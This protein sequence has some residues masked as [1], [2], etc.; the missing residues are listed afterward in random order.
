[1][2]E[3]VE[4]AL[5]VR[6]K[7]ARRI[8]KANK[9]TKVP[10]SLLDDP[11][12]KAAIDNLPKNYNFEIPKI[13]WRIKE[14]NSKTVALQMPEGLLLYATTIADIIEDFSD[15]ETIIMGDVTYG[16]CCIDDLTAKSLGVDLMVHFGHSCLVTVDQTKGIK[17][18]YIFVDIK[19]DPLHFLETIKYNFPKTTK[20]GLVS[21]IQ[22]LTTLQ[23]VANK[24]KEFEYEVILPQSKPLSAGEILGCTAPALKCTDAVIYLGDG[25]FHLEAIMIANPKIQA[26]KYDPYKK[27]FTREYYEYDKMVSIRRKNIDKSSNSKNFGVIMGTLGRQGNINV[28]EHTRKSLEDKDKRVAVILLS[29]I[30][31]KKLEL[32]PQLDT[33]VQ[34]ACPRL[35]IDW[36]ESFS[37]PLLTPYELTVAIGNMQWHHENKYPMDFY[38]SSSLGPWTPNHKPGVDESKSCCGKCA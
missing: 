32:F 17:V 14:T 35:S 4:N 30:F 22:F 2:G 28:V 1:M 8:F 7:P 11:K 15:A 5:V 10:Q 25:R 16:A 31:P 21:T 34:I 6:A 33:F 24:L 36:G 20:L 13:L 26:Y 38:A 18:L 3:P 12:L 37:K 23:A 19:I 29:E 9:I 27:E